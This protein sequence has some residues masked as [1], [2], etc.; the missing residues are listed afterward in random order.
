MRS[1]ERDDKL[2]HAREV[3]ARVLGPRS[4]GTRIAG[5]VKNLDDWRGRGY[6]SRSQMVS[7][8]HQARGV[9]DPVGAATMAAVRVQRDDSARIAG[10]EIKRAHE[11][12]RTEDGEPMV[13]VPDSFEVCRAK[14][15]EEVEAIWLAV[16][17]LENLVDAHVEMSTRS[18]AEAECILCAGL[19][20]SVKVYAAGRC[21]WHYD[22]RATWEDSTT[23]EPIDAHAELG[24]SH[25]ERPGR[26]VTERLVRQ[27]HPNARRRAEAS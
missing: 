15:D 16:R 4:G 19:G 27:Y 14:I 18:R 3:L 24:R 7:D 6:G 10:V 21:S 25:L 5:A 26:Y 13:L 1:T 23:G 2:Q 12:G 17:R 11:V 8:I 22:F 20:R 9:Q